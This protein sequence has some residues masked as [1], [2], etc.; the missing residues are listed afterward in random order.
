[1]H[2]ILIFIVIGV[3]IAFQIYF[4][5]TN[6]MAIKKYKESLS[7]VKDLEVVENEVI[8]DNEAEVELFVENEGF[9]YDEEENESILFEEDEDEEDGLLPF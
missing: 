1:M 3:I 5:W 9:K 2:D 8:D 4:F 7:Q 6:N